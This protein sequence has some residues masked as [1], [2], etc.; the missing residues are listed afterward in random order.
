L[1]QD[2]SLDHKNS[3]YPDE[4]I[5]TAE[6]DNWQVSYLDIMTILLGFL[7]ILL[8]VTTLTEQKLS[9][10]SKLF[11][12][13]TQETEFITTPIEQI[14]EELEDALE[15]DIDANKLE[16]IRDLNDIRIR[17]SSDELY[18]SGSAT[19]QQSALPLFDHVLDAITSNHFNDFNIDVEGHT[20]NTPISSSA[21]PSNWELSTARAINVVK[22][23]R[24]MGINDSRLKASGFADSQPLVPNE[25]AAGLSL[26]KNKAINR[27]VDIRLYYSSIPDADSSGTTPPPV[28]AQSSEGCAYS[29]Q[30][31]ESSSFTQSF[32]EASAAQNKTGLRFD[33][34]YN[35]TLYSI[36]TQPA[37]SLEQ[38][39]GIQQQLAE[40]FPNNTLGVV[41]QCN[42]NEVSKPS[43]I[44]YHI[45]LAAF[46]NSGNAKKYAAQVSSKHKVKASVKISSKGLYKVMAG[47]Y[48]NPN[49]AQKTVQ[50]LRKE[51]LPKNIFVSPILGTVKPYTFQFE[52]QVA[53]FSSKKEAEDLS[54]K[55]TVLMGLNTKIS[56]SNNG[57]FYLITKPFT[58]RATA[59][60]IFT[61]LTHTSY[62]LSPVWYFIEHL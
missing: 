4:V 43:P 25:N 18:Q 42:Q 12:S 40:K 3:L 10:V 2:P 56:R 54:R 61:D 16:I 37:N 23:F 8:S 53:S 1:S 20:D 35:R 39:L 24:G 55:L 62:K 19:L 46:R 41:H 49:V 33:I 58:D 26:P 32:T 36:R 38:A 57:I 47:P 30:L 59:Q 13:S 31:D 5:D 14:Q 52:V 9:S 44:Q 51:G 50:R 7:L 29:V 15:D 34:T 11:K 6:D 60:Q 21:Y 27:R 17:F 45:Q 48:E 28:L 22:Y